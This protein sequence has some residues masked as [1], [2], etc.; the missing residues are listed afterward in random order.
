[1]KSEIREKLLATGAIAAGFAEAGEVDAVVAANFERW[2]R[3]GC[4]ADAEYLVT[5]I[6]LRRHTDNVLPGAKTVISLAYSYVPRRWRS[7]SLPRVACYAYGLDYHKV[8]RKRLKQVVKG[9]AERFGGDWRI[10]IDSAPLE[11]RYWALKSGLG[12][13]GLNGNV[14]VEGGG[15]FCFL[16]EILTTIRIEPDKPSREV[17][18]ECGK[19][20]TACPTGALNS[21][22][23]L[24][25]NLCLNHQTIENKTGINPDVRQ[26]LKKRSQENMFLFGCDICQR[27]CPHNQGVEPTHIEEFNP[28]EGIL[29]INSE[30]ILKMNEEDFRVRFGKTALKRGGLERL[31]QNVAGFST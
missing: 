16:T 27:I 1:M 24:D 7:E 10:C 21:D 5:H 4:H 8:I 30:E 31:K 20:L 2:I 25:C 3:R 9:L 17:C 15:S 23:T 26:R 14:I 6:P 29:E 12:K 11:E 18:L 22:G 28:Q 19:C 13:R